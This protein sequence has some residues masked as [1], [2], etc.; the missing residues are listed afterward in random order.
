MPIGVV[1]QDVVEEPDRVLRRAHQRVPIDLRMVREGLVDEGA[2]V[3]GA[4]AA[5]T[6]ILQG[7]FA[8]G[9]DPLHLHLVVLGRRFPLYRVPEDDSRLVRLPRPLDE[10]LPDLPRPD[11]PVELHLLVLELQLE[12]LISLDRPH[13]G[14]RDLDGDVRIVDLLQVFLDVDEV[15]YVGVVHAYRYHLG[16]SPPRLPYRPRRRGE[17]LHE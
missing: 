16:A 1:V 17:E 15:D 10:L 12:I 11:L 9:V 4:Q 13:E 5:V 7:L 8:A 2:Q 6:V 3:H 14:V